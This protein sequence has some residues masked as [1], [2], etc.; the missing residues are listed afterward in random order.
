MANKQSTSGEYFPN[1][2]MYS[3]HKGTSLFIYLFIHDLSIDVVGRSDYI[4]V[5]GQM[6]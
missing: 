2:I 1:F 6:L 3:I 4:V 5:P